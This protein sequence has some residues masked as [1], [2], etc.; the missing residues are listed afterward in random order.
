MH[1]SQEDPKEKGKIASKFIETTQALLKQ[2]NRDKRFIINMDQTPFN[3]KDSNTKTLAV[4]GSK[5]VNAKEIK[6]SVGRVTVC[7]TVCADGTKLPPL[8]TKEILEMLSKERSRTSPKELFTVS[9]PMHG[10]TRESLSFGLTK[11]SPRMSKPHHLT[12][13]TI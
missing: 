12:S 6:T 9:K 10:Q 3:P 8:S 13:S 1:K 2:R 7:L 5:T 4:K 11:S